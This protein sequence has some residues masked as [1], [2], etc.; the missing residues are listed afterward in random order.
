[1][2]SERGASGGDVHLKMS[3]EPAE[4]VTVRLAE[5]GM[6]TIGLDQRKRGRP[7]HPAG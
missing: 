4:G 3:R 6:P 7:P 1:M 5:Q 2:R